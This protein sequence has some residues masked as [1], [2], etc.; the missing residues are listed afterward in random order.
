MSSHD[1]TLSRVTGVAGTVAW[2]TLVVGR[3]AGRP[4]SGG[5]ARMAR[6][7]RRT[8]LRGGLAA[9][10]LPA[11]GLAAPGIYRASAS[12]AGP[13]VV[14][15]HGRSAAWERHGRLAR[16]AGLEREVGGCGVARVVWGAAT[17]QRIV[18]L[19][20]DDGPSAEYTAAV[21]DVL[22]A[23]RARA[24]FFVVGRQIRRFPEL[25]RRQ[26]DEGHEHG[27]HTDT[28]ADLS[29]LSEEAVR[30]EL[31]A[32]EQALVTVTGRRPTLM[33][34]PYGHLSGASLAA[35]AEL[36]YDVALWTSAFDELGLDAP[37]NVAHLAAGLRPGGVVLGHD[38]GDARRKVGLAALP[39]LLVRLQEAG[40]RTVTM[41]ELIAA[42]RP[43]QA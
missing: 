39:G 18:A 11:L 8:V 37:G 38:Q 42:D 34:P 10:G 41:S 7:G 19:T 23:A 3:N 1:D 5:E 13:Q 36:G 31:H 35:S 22:A 16:A 2:D 43:A 29:V 30:D 14:P 26:R 4:G 17:T 15:V 40:Y 12:E 27:N 25:V 20:F 33:R 21:L 28:H 24:T 6:L 9:L 32:A